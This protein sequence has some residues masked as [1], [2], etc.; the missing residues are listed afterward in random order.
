MLR[1]A[2]KENGLLGQSI[3]IFMK[4]IKSK[5]IAKALQLSA[6]TVSLALN[7]KPGVNEETRRRVEEYLAKE[8]TRLYGAKSAEQQEDKGLLISL[9]YIKS[10]I[11]MNRAMGKVPTGPDIFF[12]Q[13]RRYGYHLETRIYYEGNENLGNL[14]EE[15]QVRNVKGIYIIAAEMNQDDIYPFLNL[16]IPVVVGDNSFYEFGIDSYLLDNREGIRSGIKY[17][18]DRGHS[19]IVYL[20]ENIDIYNF[21]ERREAFVL[22]MARRECGDVR[23]RIVHMGNTEEEVYQSTLEYLDSGRRMPT[24]FLLESS[25]VSVGVIKAL[26]ERKVR[27]PKDI[28]LVGFDALPPVGLKSFSLTQ[29]KGIHTKRHMAAIRHLV[30]H[31]E[32]EDVEIIRV[33]Y[34]TRMIDGNS[35]FD[36]TQYIY[37]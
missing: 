19:H 5:D 16:G 23:N 2:G 27:I 21:I 7:H 18:M 22:E 13:A 35:V 30:A 32:E 33:Y 17:L 37:R 14:L 6:A 8:E 34:K 3:L 10:G 24:A 12:E 11:V 15:F 1:Q 28:S 20:A 31:I 36:K 4:K 25:V 26:L 9:Q 29:I